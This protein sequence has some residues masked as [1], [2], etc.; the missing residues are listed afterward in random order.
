MAVFA[1]VDP[2]TGNPSFFIKGV[3]PTIPADAFAVTDADWQT[4]LANQNGY[5][6]VNGVLTAYTPPAPAPTVPDNPTLGDWRVALTL[7]GRMDDVT[8]KVAALVASTDPVQ[9]MLGKI[10]SE[11]LNY[12]NNVLRAQLL[13]L[14]DAFGF[15]SDDVD[16]SLYR[17]RQVSLGDLSGVW[18]LPASS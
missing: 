17:A 12:S 16:E 7:W 11:R 14:K 6:F 15:T 10:A 3:S 4:Y 1:T 9:H 8:S 13:Q 18:P 2:N 5:R